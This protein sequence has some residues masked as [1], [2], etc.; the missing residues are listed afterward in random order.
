MY[1]NPAVIASILALVQVQALPENS[2]A[3][4]AYVS[5]TT[6]CTSKT[7]ALPTLVST[8][9]PCTSNTAV[10][11]TLISTSTPCTS[12]TAV[13]PTLLSTSTPCTSTQ[14]KPTLT[15]D[16]IETPCETPIPTALPTLLT[17]SMSTGAYPTSLPDYN[18][19]A[20]ILSSGLS[21]TAGT[22]LMGLIGSL[23]LF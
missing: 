2:Q 9:T 7:S 22:A 21:T 6:P 15:V 17:K 14:V 23:F 20:P 13:L 4:K 5:T 18:Q 19:N 3:S 11:P 8:S 16:P 1:F 12:S 10:L